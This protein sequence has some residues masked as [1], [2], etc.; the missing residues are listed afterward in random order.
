MCR[1][2]SGG[3]ANSMLQFQLKGRDD[4]TKALLEY[5]ENA[6]ISSWLHENET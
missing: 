3:G 2:A 5:E 6:V 1:M 4:G